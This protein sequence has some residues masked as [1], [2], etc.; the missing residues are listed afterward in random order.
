MASIE[1]SEGG[2]PKHSGVADLIVKGA[3]ALVTAAFFIG[4]YLQFQMSFWAALIGAAAV[5]TVLLLVH[6]LRHRTQREDDLVSELTRL[7]DEVQRIK[8]GPRPAEG[9][10]RERAPTIMPPPVVKAPPVPAT[11][12]APIA[13]APMP[14]MPPANSVNAPEFNPP[15]FN[16]PEFN[17][18]P[19]NPPGALRT[20]PADRMSEREPR[21]TSLRPGDF[22][23]EAPRPDPRL[24]DSPLPRAEEGATREFGSAPTLPGWPA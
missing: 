10:R 17:A 3:I 16:P 12:R 2:M 24:S 11:G 21:L 19:V 1:N 20:Q 8:G 22:G 15:E 13:R 9:A 18:P 14:P 6:S 23:A 7:E 4:A 5:Y